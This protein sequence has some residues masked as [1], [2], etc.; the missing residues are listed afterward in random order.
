[1]KKII[2]NLAISLDGMIEG[3]GGEFDWCFTDQDYGMTEFMDA[4]DSVF[5]GRKS[6]EL[7]LKMG[8]DVEIPGG[9][10]MYAGKTHYVFSNTL[11]SVAE[12]FQL[13]S[14]N[15]QA[16]VEALRREGGKDIWFFGGAN[17]LAHFMN[18]GLIDE[19]QLSLHP[20]VLGG[21]TP[22]FQ[23]IAARNWFDL[24]SVQQYDSGL[25]QLV[26]RRK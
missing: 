2:L 22:L 25:V 14:G 6:Y 16:Q 26:Y 9:G 8:Q 12:G 21:G 4:V 7:M 20:V 19:M 24:V 13:I 10:D 15:W 17:L 3:S 5:Y 18:S 23:D 11:K 1:M